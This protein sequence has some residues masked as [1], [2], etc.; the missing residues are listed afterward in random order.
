MKIVDL[1]LILLLKLFLAVIGLIFIYPML[2]VRVRFV[3]K[4][5][6]KL[7]DKCTVGLNRCDESANR[8]EKM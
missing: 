2:K 3:R 7:A 5:G 8:L 4:F 1:L 6:R